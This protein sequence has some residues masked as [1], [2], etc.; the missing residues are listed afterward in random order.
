MS[1]LQHGGVGS[2]DPLEIVNINA[3][4][5]ELDNCGAPQQQRSDLFVEFPKCY[6]YTLTWALDAAAAQFFLDERRPVDS[7]SDFI[8]DRMSVNGITGVSMRLG[9]PNGRFSSNVRV[10]SLALGG[11]GTNILGLGDGVVIPAG[12]WIGIEAAIAANTAAD[13]LVVGFEGRVR[14]YLRPTHQQARRQFT[15]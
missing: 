5:L 1:W 2:V 9:W 10:D 7:N 6:L 14:Y 4:D 11:T 12:Q 15:R 8:L 3:V 13:T